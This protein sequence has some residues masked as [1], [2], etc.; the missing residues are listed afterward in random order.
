MLRHQLAV[1]THRT[2]SQGRARLRLCDK[3]LWIL[4]RRCCANWRQHLSFVTPE[5]VVRWHRQ[6]WR[7]FWRWKSRVPPDPLQ[8]RVNATFRVIVWGVSPIGALMGGLLGEAVGLRATLLIGA[9]GVFLEFGWVLFSPVRSLRQLPV[10]TDQ[11]A[12]ILA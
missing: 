7:L 9:L 12:P 3:L 4:A 5:T 8:G 1:L 11:P 2:R 6:G 10:P